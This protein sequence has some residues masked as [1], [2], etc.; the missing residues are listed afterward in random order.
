DPGLRLRRAATQAT[1][2]RAISGH[3]ARR[4]SRKAAGFQPMARF[5]PQFAEFW[6][7]GPNFGPIP[8]KPPN[9]P[10]ASLPS[11]LSPPEPPALSISTLT[12]PEPSTRDTPVVRLTISLSPRIRFRPW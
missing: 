1:R 2:L 6:R 7:W 9:P 10:L 4:D 12:G 8:P 5:M 3:F 11:L